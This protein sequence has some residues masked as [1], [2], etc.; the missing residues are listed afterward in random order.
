[1]NTMY[2]QPYDLDATGFFFDSFEEYEEKAEKNINSYGQPVEEYEIQSLESSYP[3]EVT[4]GDL[5]EWLE[6]SE[7]WEDMD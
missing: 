3:V 6:Q 4:Q 1:M 5:E 2:A 7:Q